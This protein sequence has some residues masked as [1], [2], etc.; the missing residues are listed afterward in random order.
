M[1]HA[2]KVA[3]IAQAATVLGFVL[4]AGTAPMWGSS[5]AR[6]AK[7]QASATASTPLGIMQ[8]MA[9]FKALPE[10]AFEAF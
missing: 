4:L 3:G 9:T 6:I 1:H 2:A 5:A 10:Q 8:M 7:S